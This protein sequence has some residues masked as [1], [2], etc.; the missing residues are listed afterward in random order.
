MPTEL[1]YVP[2]VR[3]G[4]RAYRR[5][6][7]RFG[8]AM[9]LAPAAVMG[10]LA[11]LALYDNASAVRGLLGF[12]LAILAAPCLLLAGVPLTTGASMYAVAFV[13]SAV[14]WVALGSLAAKRATRRPVAMWGDFWREFLWLAAGVW[15][16]VL[17]SLAAIDLL[18]GG[19]F[20]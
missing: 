18:L 8:P 20:L 15:V 11:W 5:R 12:V 6:V 9:G 1:A 14:I 7:R 3:Q 16:G 10:G 13:A 2:P 19:V 17:V 4:P